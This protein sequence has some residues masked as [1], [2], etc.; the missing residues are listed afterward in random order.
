MKVEYQPMF[1]TI[2]ISN[3]LVN[4]IRKVTES[5]LVKATTKIKDTVVRE[6]SY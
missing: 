6:Y 3:L 2:N 4:A 1:M 5:F